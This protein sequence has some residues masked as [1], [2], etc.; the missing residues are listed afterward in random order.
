MRTRL[1]PLA[2]LLLLALD[3]PAYAHRD[4]ISFTTNIT[5]DDQ[6]ILTCADIDM[7]FWRESKGDLVTARRDQSV[8]LALSGATPF[9]L[10]AA[11]HGGI[12]V[13]AASG[14]SASAVL[15]MAAGAKSQAAADAVL[16]KL[17]VVNT[18]DGLSV[19]GP[20]GEDWAVYILVSVPKDV[21]LDLE[22]ENGGLAVIGVNGSFT[23]RTTN[24]PISIVDVTGKVDAEA[25]NGPI[26]F[27]GH[28]GDMRLAAQ[29]GPVTVKL[30]APTWTGDGLEASTQNGPVSLSAPDGL[31][32]GVHIEGSQHSP[33]Q[34]NGTTLVRVDDGNWGN[35]RS[36]RLGEGPVRVRLSTVNG[37]V[38]V[39]GAVFTKP[40]PVKRTAKRGEI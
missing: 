27:R 32:T 30:D 39:R 6:S 37:P 4:G 18:S 31:R 17:D 40:A 16:D 26:A 15:C 38:T 34:V 28:D 7:K 9:R 22:A 29:N 1:A 21:A 13:Q 8:S 35:N 11:D 25:T 14:S 24:G 12:R 3:G 10:R 20:E 5:K 36:V 23:L 33:F 2:L 19:R